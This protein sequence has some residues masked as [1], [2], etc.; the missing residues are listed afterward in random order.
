MTWTSERML[1]RIRE[2]MRE[3]RCSY[4]TAF[5]LMLSAIREGGC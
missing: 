3:R 2:I 1:G 5:T 4:E